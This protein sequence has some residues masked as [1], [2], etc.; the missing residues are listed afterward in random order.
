[1][2][3]LVSKSYDILEEYN[4]SNTSKFSEK[5]DKIVFTDKIEESLY[6]IL[7]LENLTINE[8]SIKLK[9]DISTLSFKLSM[10]EINNYIKKTL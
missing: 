2:A 1:M 3:K 7:L 10:M 8:L 4:I 6:N 5:K 9:I